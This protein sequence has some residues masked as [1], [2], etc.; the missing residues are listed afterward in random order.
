MTDTLA[1]RD[2]ILDFLR[3][4][5]IGPSQSPADIQPNGEEILRPQDP[6]RQRYG[7][8][9]LFPM[10][11]QVPSQDDT[12]EDEETELSAGSPE[13]G[14]IL[15][16]VENGSSRGGHTESIPETEHDVNL[17]NQ[18]LPSA[19]G[20]SV[21]VE[22][23]DTLRVEVSAAKYEQG[24]PVQLT[25]GRQGR[26]NWL[27]Q[28]IER[29]IEFTA[30]Q[31]IG[32]ES[33]SLEEPVLEVDGQQALVLHVVSRPDLEAKGGGSSHSLSSTALSQ[34]PR[35]PAIPNVSSSADFP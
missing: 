30:A 18:Y 12:A 32:I 23:P 34:V 8:G 11:A 3:S 26:R 15:Q 9:V 27:R 28:P 14:D 21:L 25:S 2:F 10:K 4:E 29:T 6:P 16:E 1:A 19:M 24:D 35:R 7:A 13:H 33:V 22:V 20:L 31:L 17:A 5:L